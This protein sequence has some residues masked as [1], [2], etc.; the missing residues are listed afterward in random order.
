[1]CKIRR[2]HTFTKKIATPSKKRPIPT[3][4]RDVLFEFHLKVWN[5]ASI[6]I[7]VRSLLLNK[8]EQLL[9]GIKMKHL[10]SLL[11]HLLDF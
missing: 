3:L 7:P 10:K 8:K 5:T 6:G 11:L 9:N 1:M 4:S 2:Q